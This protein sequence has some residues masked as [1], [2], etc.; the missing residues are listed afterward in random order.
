[1]SKTIG[2]VLGV[3]LGL[4]RVGLAVSDEMGIAVRALENRKPQ[5]RQ[6]DL[7]FF[8]ELCEKE[9]ITH[10]VVGYPIMPDCETEGPMA[11]RARSFSEL[12][13]EQ[14]NK[15]GLELKVH[16]QDERMTSKDAT[17]RLLA[18]D[19]SQKRRKKLLDGEVA[20][21]LVEAFLE[22]TS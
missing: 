12:L 6:A 18:S 8:I 14:A 22:L 19:V 10:V 21:M 16:L 9:E 13:Q 5:S 17:K 20:R 7:D 4:K 15:A 2:R 3:D 11:K 1:M